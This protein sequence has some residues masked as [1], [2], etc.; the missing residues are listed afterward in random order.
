V[1]PGAK[2]A[3]SSIALVLLVLIGYLEWR[4]WTGPWSIPEVRRLEA[5]V[6]AQREENEALRQRN[7]RSAADVQDLKT[8]KEAVEE[9][10]R[11][12]LGMTRPGVVFY[13]VV[14]PPGAANGKAAPDAAAPK[15]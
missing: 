5:R 2:L 15:Q 7:A 11:A 12:E 13:Q 4:L 10:A 6:K 1:R 9:R 14:V 8:G 3:F